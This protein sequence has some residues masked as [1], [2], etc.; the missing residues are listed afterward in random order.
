M[1]V[2]V[3]VSTVVLN[4][5]RLTKNIVAISGSVNELYH[6]ERDTCASGVDSSRV[7]VIEF[8]LEKF[9]ISQSGA[10]L[11]FEAFTANI[12]ANYDMHFGQWRNQ[13]AKIEASAC[14]IVTTLTPQTA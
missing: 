7:E 4:E 2:S 11:L 1:A 13:P 3:S 14:S 8:A 10:E 9:K 5:S 12:A 6:P